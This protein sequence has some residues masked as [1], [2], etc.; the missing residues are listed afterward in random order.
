MSLWCEESETL[1]LPYHTG[2]KRSRIF[3]FVARGTERAVTDD[4][5]ALWSGR[6]VLEPRQGAS[7]QGGGDLFVRIYV[8]LSAR[9]KIN[10]L[11]IKPNSEQSLI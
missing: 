10:V 1:F 2:I 5:A 9:D 4:G 11:F 3:S 6:E 8:T 7:A